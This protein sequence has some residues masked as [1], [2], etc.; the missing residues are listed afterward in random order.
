VSRTR[1]EVIVNHACCLHEC[2]ADRRADELES[3]SQQIAAHSVGFRGA[4]GYV[5]E[6]FANDSELGAANKGSR[7]KR[8]NFRILF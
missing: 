1:D 7:D 4:R 8:R 2:V 5:S 6:D 3:A